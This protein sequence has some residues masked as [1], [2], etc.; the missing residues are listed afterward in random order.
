METKYGVYLENSSDNILT[1]AS[2]PWL[3]IG[4]LP[5]SYSRSKAEAYQAYIVPEDKLPK[6]VYFRFKWWR[7]AFDKRSGLK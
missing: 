5:V 4:D 3:D 1:L 2:M 7:R 6:T